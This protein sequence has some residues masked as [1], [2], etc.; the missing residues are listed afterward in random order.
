M[1]RFGAPRRSTRSL[2]SGR[3]RWR[4]LLLVFS[5]GLVLLAMNEARRPDR[6]RWL[7]TGAVEHPVRSETSGDQVLSESG[8]FPGVDPAQLAAI[9]DQTFFQSKEHDA[10]FHLFSLLRSRSVADLNRQAIG[11]GFVA[12]HEQPAVYRGRLV[13]VAG[14]A[15]RAVW[16]K[17]PSNSLDI[18]GYYQIVMRPAGGPDWPIFIYCLELPDGFPTGESIDAEIST[19]GLFFKD[20]AYRTSAASGQGP[21]LLSAPTLVAKSVA[22]T[23]APPTGGESGDAPQG[24][25]LVAVAVVSA[26]IGLATAMLLFRRT[27]SPIMPAALRP[28]EMDDLAIAD[29]LAQRAASQPEPPGDGA[30]V[31][32]D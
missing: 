12:L 13:R 3:D 9:E 18:D 2:I 8:Y 14:D 28:G 19:S 17:A 24:W 4:L 21:A 25:S 26:V 32:D 30:R 5:L 23:P 16:L 6:W 31:F 27:K 20:L 1:I 15:R 10:W 29:A 11:V 22:W 7:W